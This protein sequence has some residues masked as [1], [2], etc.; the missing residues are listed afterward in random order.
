MIKIILNV[1][2]IGDGCSDS[3]DFK[4]ELATWA[5]DNN[6]TQ[7]SLS[8]LLKIIQKHACFA[9]LPLDARTLLKTPKDVAI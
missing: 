6:I 7:A 9:N 5:V 4:F 2:Q 1:V 3:N 8:K